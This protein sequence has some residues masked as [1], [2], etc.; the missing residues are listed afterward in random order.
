MALKPTNPKKI[1]ITEVEFRQKLKNK[2][3]DFQNR[4]FNFAITRDLLQETLG[5][6]EDGNIH[7]NFDLDFADS[8]FQKI[9]VGSDILDID[10]FP[11]VIFSRTVNFS[12]ATFSKE[13]K[14]DGA[15]FS[16]EVNFIATTFSGEADFHAATFSR[17]A[18][19]WQAKFSKEVNFIATTFS[20]KADFHAATFSREAHFWQAKF[21]GKADFEGARFSG[22]VSFLGA[23]FS[24]KA[25]FSEARFSREANFSSAKFS[26]KADFSEARFSREAN[27]SSAKFSNR[28][29]F[30]MA[31]FSEKADFTV[32]TFSGKAEFNKATL[33][34]KANFSSARFLDIADFGYVV[35][36]QKV[37]F[38]NTIFL[39]EV[40]FRRATFSQNHHT[41]FCNLNLKQ[42]DNTDKKD[43]KETYPVPSLQFRDTIFPKLV[44][45]S[46]CN[47]SQTTF[48]SCTIA[49]I[50]FRSCEFAKTGFFIFKRNAFENRTRQKSFWKN[51]C[52]ALKLEGRL[53]KKAFSKNEDSR[54]TK[55]RDEIEREIKEIEKNNEKLQQKTQDK[56]QKL[57]TNPLKIAKLNEKL[58]SIELETEEKIKDREDLCCQ[59]KTALESNKK[60]RQA[61]DFYIGELEARR[62]KNWWEYLKLSFFK[63]L[64][65]YAEGLAFYLLV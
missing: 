32:A 3:G 10:D 26:G 22:E 46:N 17:E 2:D 55:K 19:F 14:F 11:K 60:W 57:E 27:F 34:G 33:S 8:E 6:A 59:M 20:G 21:S 39:N 49:D 5:L 52:L 18:H 16:K 53:F 56:I 24:G 45:F 65:G 62:S 13:A 42:K 50:K 23:R 63:Y 4:I 54:L 12:E 36:L 31:A 30:F 47:L 29:Y 1:P 40:Q 58:H 44:L 28:T 15:T 64:L 51:F 37:D 7:F 9:D 25:D 35:F 41:Y 43:E 61:G 48:E 38:T